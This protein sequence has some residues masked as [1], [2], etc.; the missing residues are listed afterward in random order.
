[1]PG[2]V[3]TI[4][5]TRRAEDGSTVA[6]LHIITPENEQLTIRDWAYKK[7]DDKL[8]GSVFKFSLPIPPKPEDP[9]SKMHGDQVAPFSD[10]D[11]KYYDGNA[12]HWNYETGK[13]EGGVAAPGFNDALRGT[14]KA[15]HINGLS[16]ND[17]IQGGEGDDLIEGNDGHDLLLG[18]KGSDRIFGGDGDDIL[19]GHSDGLERE[20]Y[21]RH[22]DDKMEVP[23]YL[24][25]THIDG[26]LWGLVKESNNKKDA[27]V[28]IGAHS[29]QDREDSSNTSGDLLVGG[30]GDDLIYGSREHDLI[31][32]GSEDGE[33]ALTK[34]KE[35]MTR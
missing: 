27:F 33:S 28:L 22:S 21:W 19:M 24:E 17:A 9:K 5:T 11:K 20:V 3:F 6:D 14:E 13:L 4:G 30:T 15:D 35:F 25:R 34:Q 31:Y 2:Y 10:K 12:T 29:S 16:G 7:E 8:T 32:G 1:M 18:G 26:D 23:A